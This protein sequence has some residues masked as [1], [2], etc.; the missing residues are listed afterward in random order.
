MALSGDHDLAKV[1][2]VDRLNRQLRGWA[3]F[4]KYTDFTATTFRHIGYVVFW[5]MAHCWR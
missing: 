2:M 1:D 3:A 5:K 4:Y